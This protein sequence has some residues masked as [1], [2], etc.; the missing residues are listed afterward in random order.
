MS[1]KSVG[2][3]GS[4]R[5]AT[6]FLGGWARAGAMPETVVVFDCN[7]D[8]VAKLRSQHPGIRVGTLA[9]AAG[10][11][12]VLL[13]VHPPIIG[14]VLP[15]VKPAL[16]A[17]AILVSLAPKST[18]A[19]LTEMLGG[20]R[21]IARMIP[22]APSIVGK[23]YNPTAFGEAL[24]EQDRAVLRKLFNG[25]GE[26][27]EVPEAHLEVYAVVSAM[28]LTFLWPQ[29]DM[30]ATL[31]ETSGLSRQAAWDGIEKMLLGAVAA[32]RD[33]GLPAAGVQDLVP[34]KPV[35]DEV[36]AFVGAARPKLDGLLAKLRP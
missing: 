7:Q 24:G 30:L 28:G 31:A 9:E 11:D 35:A 17:D 6:I 25:L 13:A 12:I 5:I 32:M 16:K 14:S 36:H 19:K 33:S 2:F 23:G 26:C 29:L 4:G 10:Q 22:N 20:F 15:Q 34:V 27:A 3:I 21:R 18:V 8:V 1:T